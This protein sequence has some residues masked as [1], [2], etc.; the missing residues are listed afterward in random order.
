MSE[1]E[2]W[3]Y[4]VWET[5]VISYVSFLHSE[6]GIYSFNDRLNIE[7]HC[8]CSEYCNKHDTCIVEEKND[9]HSDIDNDIIRR[10]LS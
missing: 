1:E 2:L 10:I 8:C 9:L 4:V 3:I 6:I 5:K 7:I